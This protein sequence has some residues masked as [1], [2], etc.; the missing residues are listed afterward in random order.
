M[1]SILT[2][3]FPLGVL[4]FS[5]VHGMKSM[6]TAPSQFISPDEAI[7]HQRQAYFAS[8]FRRS[9]EEM[10]ERIDPSVYGKMGPMPITTLNSLQACDGKS[11]DATIKRLMKEVGGDYDQCLAAFDALF[12]KGLVDFSFDRKVNQTIIS[13]TAAGQEQLFKE[14]TKLTRGAAYDALADMGLDD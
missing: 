3:R 12:N 4:D 5:M 1:T 13:L 10:C 7:D 14:R 8:V 9:L 6:R 2:K 11:L